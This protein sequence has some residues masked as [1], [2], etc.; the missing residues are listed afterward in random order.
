M[1]SIIASW[2]DVLTTF[3][4]NKY[5]QTYDKA[6]LDFRHNRFY[7]ELKGRKVIDVFPANDKHIHRGLLNITP[8]DVSGFFSNIPLIVYPDDDTT[9][10]GLIDLVASSYGV[11]FDK[12]IDLDKT[13]LEAQFRVDSTLR[14]VEVTIATTS[15]IWEGKFTIQYKSRGYNLNKE[16]VNRNLDVLIIPDIV[17]PN[18]QSLEL[19]TTPL[20]ITD[21][22]LL[23][24]FSGSKPVVIE[25]DTLDRLMAEIEAQMIVDASDANELRDLFNGV[26]FNSVEED[27]LPFDHYMTTATALNSG[28]WSGFPRIKFTAVAVEN[29]IDKLIGTISTGDAEF[30]V[31]ASDSF[32]VLSG[33]WKRHMSSIL[34]E[35]A[36]LHPER[37][38]DVNDIFILGV[39]KIFDNL[40]L[41][42]IHKTDKP[43]F[44]NI[45]FDTI[46]GSG[47]TGR[48]TVEVPISRY[49]VEIEEDSTRENPIQTESTDNIFQMENNIVVVETADGEIRDGMDTSYFYQSNKL[50]DVDL[51]ALML[52]DSTEADLTGVVKLKTGVVSTN[53]PAIRA[54]D[55]SH[56][57]WPG[58]TIRTF[59]PDNI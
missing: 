59:L 2:Q 31:I 19:I 34:A 50:E 52:I 4:N 47:Y 20:V 41:S 6:D 12:D 5:G 43:G 53:K 24:L 40:D 44:C 13:F 46:E 23:K 22:R 11:V 29:D 9:G 25:G 27:N 38:Q 32:N 45:Y 30:G 26:S 39:D 56:P 7:K 15:M 16:V 51:V 18:T 36:R 1:L 57:D 21:S 55:Y 10:S 37:E 3:V 49:S 33:S 14:G 48:L 17:Q 28:K 35:H 8:Y 54:N 58:V 42:D